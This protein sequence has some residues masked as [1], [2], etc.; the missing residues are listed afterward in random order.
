MKKQNVESLKRKLEVQRGILYACEDIFNDIRY[1][2]GTDIV[3][4]EENELLDFPQWRFIN[5]MLWNYLVLELHKIYSKSSNDKYRIQPVLN[6]LNDRFNGLAFKDKLSRES[7]SLLLKE[8][9][10]D[11]FA[12]HFKKLN[13]IRDKYIA[14]LDIDRNNLRI[15]NVDIEYFLELNKQIIR[16]VIDPIENGC[17][18][19]YFGNPSTIKSFV[20]NISS[21]KSVYDKIESAIVNPEERKK[22]NPATE[23]DLLRILGK[24]NFVIEG[25]S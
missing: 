23:V 21:Y 12:E 25:I 18:S 6:E 15:E 1:L 22:L 13:A 8:F 19:H 24:R 4:E 5:E 11:V 20:R 14:H 3:S 10:G 2:Q 9:N 17:S 16:E 7:I